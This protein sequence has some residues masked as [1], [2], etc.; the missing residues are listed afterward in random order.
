MLPCQH[1]YCKSCVDLIFDCGDG[2]CLNCR[3][4]FLRK[5]VM[6]PISLVHQ[7]LAVTMKYSLLEEKE[8]ERYDQQTP[9]PTKTRGPVE[10]VSQRAMMHNYS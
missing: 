4:L 6:K 2:T 8:A 7:L 10:V 5:H 9:T 1:T 3:R